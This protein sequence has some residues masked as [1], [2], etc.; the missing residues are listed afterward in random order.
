[1]NAK[2]IGRPRIDPERRKSRHI[3][4]RTRGDLRER[5]EA[6]S[7]NSG[8]SVS[9]EVEHRLEL[10]FLY[11]RHVAELLNQIQEDR[12][13]IYKQTA[14]LSLA[15]DSLKSLLTS[16]GQQLPENL[17]KLSDASLAHLDA[18]FR[19]PVPPNVSP[20]RAAE[21]YKG[22][23]KKVFGQPTQN[24]TEPKNASEETKE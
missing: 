16:S 8:R 14:L 2:P 13:T 9:E 24:E 4:F 18:F 20:A 19:D 23:L 5:L 3:T 15:G 11:E 12:Q 22:A 17:S 21:V 10:S 7:E 1:M 6:A